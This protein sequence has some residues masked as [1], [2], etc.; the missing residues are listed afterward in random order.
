[1]EIIKWG[2]ENKISFSLNKQKVEQRWLL[3]RVG[4]THKSFTK[5]NL[6]QVQVKRRAHKK[7]TN[8]M[9]IKKKKTTSRN[10]M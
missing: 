10:S 1:L 8:H 5:I 2:E 7:N 3:E 4:Q 6:K 9:H